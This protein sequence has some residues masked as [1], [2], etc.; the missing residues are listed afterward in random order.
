MS[1]NNIG[2]LGGGFGLYGYM[3]AALQ[4]NYTTLVL[5]KYKE[6]IAVHPILKIYLHQLKFIDSELDLLDASDL[7]VFA[8]TPKMQF[9]LI[10]NLSDPSKVYFFEKPLTQDISTHKIALNHLEKLKFKY[11][12]NYAF[13]RT[14][15]FK[16]LARL[17]SIKP[18]KILINWEISK[19]QSKWK[20]ELNSGGGLF[21]YYGIH[22]ASIF[23]QLNIPIES[24]RVLMRSNLLEIYTDDNCQ[25]DINLKIE[26]SDKSRFNIK[27]LE[28]SSD[29]TLYSK[30]LISPFGVEIATD[31]L[32]PRISGIIQYYKESLNQDF[33]K[34]ASS[35]ENYVL[36]FRTSYDEQSV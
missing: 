31:K 35:F 36:E 28:S 12:V 10:R 1:I 15:W 25:F 20:T 16:E 18:L 8:R 6:I 9:D 27:V 22:F 21:H 23:K 17:S 33:F 7:L 11:S 24:I 14:D 34:N 13:M 3:P 26:F 2:I 5:S 4:S 29:K 30:N 19:P 32:D